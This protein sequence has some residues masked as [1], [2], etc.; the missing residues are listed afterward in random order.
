MMMKK[1][2]NVKRITKE[3]SNQKIVR[4]LTK[5]FEYCYEE[6]KISSMCK[7]EELVNINILQ[8]M[9]K[10]IIEGKQDEFDCLLQK[11]LSL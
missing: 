3:I 8:S 10:L 6:E 9:Y 11:S 7:L 2:N 4:H 5:F 1:S